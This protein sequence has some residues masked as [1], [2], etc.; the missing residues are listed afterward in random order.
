MLSVI[1]TFEGRAVNI[2][3]QVNSEA[4]S[5]HSGP[6]ERVVY[7]STTVTTEKPVGPPVL[8]PKPKVMDEGKVVKEVITEKY[9]T[10]LTPDA[11]VPLLAAV[12]NHSPSP[13]VRSESVKIISR[14][15]RNFVLFVAF[16]TFSFADVFF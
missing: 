12:G 6:V 7:S 14:F 8:P 13:H 10:K 4:S 16:W 2:I 3:R 5:D 1:S 15:G 11:Q 9:K